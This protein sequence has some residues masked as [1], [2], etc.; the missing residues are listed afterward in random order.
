MTD[1]RDIRL[2]EG[3]R[4]YTGHQCATDPLPFVKAAEIIENGGCVAEAFA[5]L[6]DQHRTS[7]FY[8]ENRPGLP[9]LLDLGRKKA[10]Q[11]LRQ[12]AEDLEQ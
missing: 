2:N 10:A 3:F 8:L 1:W 11:A 4:R 7:L 9:M 12:C 6:S 5:S